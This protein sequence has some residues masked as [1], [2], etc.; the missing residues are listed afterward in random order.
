VKV[1]LP[2]DSNVKS[3]VLPEIPNLTS[4]YF[5]KLSLEDPKR[6]VLSSNFYWLSKTDDV[7]DWQKSTWY[8][9][10]TSSYADMTQLQ[11]LPKVKLNISATS[12]RKNVEEETAHITISNPGRHV[13]FFVQLQ[14]KR[15]RSEH[16]V[17]PVVWQDNYV[18][19]LPGETK[20]ITA[21]YDVKELAGEAATVVVEG[22]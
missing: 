10:P 11:S 22:S 1:D 20:T 15:G 18:S 2:A 16:P 21:T 9:T 14:I 6:E 3:L 4:T 12:M 8:Y 19:L 5:L 13:A 17:L 7:L